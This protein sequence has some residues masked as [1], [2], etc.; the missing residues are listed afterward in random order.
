M[1]IL[2]ENDRKAN[3]NNFDVG[4]YPKFSFFPFFE[5]FEGAFALHS[6]LPL[7]GTTAGWEPLW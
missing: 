4:N 1:Y 2:V 3:F 7:Y 5:T 6:C